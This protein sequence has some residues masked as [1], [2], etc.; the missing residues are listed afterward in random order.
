[1]EGNMQTGKLAVEYRPLHGTSAVR[2][3]RQEGKVP[4]VCY[5]RGEEPISIAFDPKD[6]V[7]ALDPE[8]R[9]NTLISMTVSGLTD[10]AR[11]LTV[12]LRDVQRD[13]LDGEL[14]H[15]DFQRVRLDEE[16]NVVIPVL[17]LGK[18]EG[19]KLGGTLHQVYRQVQVACRPDRIPVRLEVNVDA[20]NMGD[21]LHVS[22]LKLPEGVRVLADA[23]SAICTVTAPKAEKTAAE[24]AAEA[25]AAAAL[26][27]GAVPG[28]V[29]GAPG[30]APGAAGAPGAPATAAPGKE[31]RGAERKK[32]E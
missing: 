5:G 30:A 27:E 15:A 28:A 22:D 3:L 24:E 7:R 11:E 23:D 20:L 4:G 14:L 9:R 1:M 16:L 32:K 2:K 18:P 29:P 6:L 26:V 31:E 17:L 13:T 21:A 12:L 8:K 25:A 10:G 19:V